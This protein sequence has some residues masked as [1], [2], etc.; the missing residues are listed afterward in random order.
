MNNFKG[1][2]HQKKINYSPR[3]IYFNHKIIIMSCQPKFSS[4]LFLVKRKENVF[5]RKYWL[6]GGSAE[7]AS[8]PIISQIEQIHDFVSFTNTRSRRHIPIFLKF[9]IIN[10]GKKMCFCFFVCGVFFYWKEIEKA[11]TKNVM[12]LAIQF[13][14]KWCLFQ[15]LRSRNS[16][17]RCISGGQMAIFQGEGKTHRN[18]TI[19][20]AWKIST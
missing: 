1:I 13:P 17:R 14:R 20:T 12:V 10:F 9:W 5:H 16:G 2:D 8:S 6:L 3:R 4:L 11:K 19:I 7:N 15:L 18:L